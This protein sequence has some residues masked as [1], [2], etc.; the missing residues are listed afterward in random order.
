MFCC[1]TL[2]FY[3]HLVQQDEVYTYDDCSIRCTCVNGEEQCEAYGCRGDE[4]CKVEGE[5]RGCFCK[6][7]FKFNG[8]ECSN[9]MLLSTLLTCS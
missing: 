3:S 4:E 2:T 8:F 5:V 6:E 7:G 1:L 9:G